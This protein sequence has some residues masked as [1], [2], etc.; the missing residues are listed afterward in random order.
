[1]AANKNAD[2]VITYKGVKAFK[3]THPEIKKLKRKNEAP[4]IHGNKIWDSS[5]VLMD[6]LRRWPPGDSLSVLDIGCGWGVLSSYIAREFDANVTGMDADEAVKPYFDYHADKN[7]VELDFSVGTMDS[8]KKKSLKDVDMLV[9]ADICFWPELGRD[10]K[11]LIKRALD[12]GVEQIY[13][14]DPGRSPFWDLVKHCEKNYG[15]EVWSHD[16][17]KPFKSEKYILEIVV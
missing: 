13:V 8:L 1:M 2:H 15:G 11:K 3:A 10:W 9:G 7:K 14:A 17:K 5:F 16:I 6:F 4:S 12:A